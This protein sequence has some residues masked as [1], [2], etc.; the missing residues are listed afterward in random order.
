MDSDFKTR[1]VTF[2]RKKY[3]MGMTR[4][5]EYTG[6]NSGTINKIRDGISTTTLAKIADACP[7]LNLRWLLLGEIGGPMVIPSEDE[8]VTSSRPASVNVET[9][10][11]VF[12]TN[13]KDIEGLLERTIERS[14]AKQ[15]EEK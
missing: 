11:A 13:W 9:A 2:A 6:I 3:D 1:L 4:F 5:E 8:N 14:M 10:Q 7:E 12:I 15:K